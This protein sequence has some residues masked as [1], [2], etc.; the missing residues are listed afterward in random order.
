MASPL[1]RLTDKYRP[2]KPQL[3]AT[4]AAVANGNAKRFRR[5]RRRAL[6]S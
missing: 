3:A 2:S 5:E 4:H 1:H 6:G